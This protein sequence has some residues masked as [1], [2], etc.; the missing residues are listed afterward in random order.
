MMTDKPEHRVKSCSRCYDHPAGLTG[1]D[2]CDAC[3]EANDTLWR[4]VG[5]R[6]IDADDKRAEAE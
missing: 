4:A 5:R 2:H 6:L 3:R 1:P